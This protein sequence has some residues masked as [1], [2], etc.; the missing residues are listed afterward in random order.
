MPAFSKFASCFCFCGLRG[1]YH[2]DPNR[3]ALLRFNLMDRYGAI[4]AVDDPFNQTALRVARTISKLW[5][6]PEKVVGNHESQNGNLASPLKR[7]HFNQSPRKNFYLLI[8]PE[9][10][11][12]ADHAICSSDYRRLHC[13][14]FASVRS[15]ATAVSSESQPAIWCRSDRDRKPFDPTFCKTNACYSAKVRSVS[16]ARRRHSPV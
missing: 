16:A 3:D 14:R 8:L 9:S 5:H 6:R 4:C 10:D 12:T 15:V 2:I 11:K 1:F 7:K 13:V